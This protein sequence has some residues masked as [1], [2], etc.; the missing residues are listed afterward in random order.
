MPNF[1]LYR[2]VSADL[3]FIL[4][5][6]RLDGYD[7]VVGR[8]SEERH[9]AALADSGHAYFVGRIDG[10]PAG[11]AILRDWASPDRVTTLQRIAVAAPGTGVGRRILAA[12]IDRVFAETDCHRFWLGVFPDNLRARRAYEAV[13]FVPEGVARGLAFFGGA[14]RDELIMAIL[15]TDRAAAQP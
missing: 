8:W 11:F 13:G 6:E 3:P 7:S 10:A 4:A 15:R 1:R 9:R 12:V 5:T 2:A 14:H